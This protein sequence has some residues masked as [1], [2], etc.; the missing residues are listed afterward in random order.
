VLLVWFLCRRRRRRQ[1]GIMFIPGMGERVVASSMRSV[2]TS[3]SSIEGAPLHALRLA[4]AIKASKRVLGGRVHTRWPGP[5][6]DSKTLAAARRAV[7]DAAARHD[8]IHSRASGSTSS[9]DDVLSVVSSGAPVPGTPW[10]PQPPLSES[11]Q[12][13]E[14]DLLPVRGADQDP[15][16]Q[17]LRAERERVNAEVARMDAE[18]AHLRNEYAEGAPPTYISDNGSDGASAALT[19]GGVSVTPATHIRTSVSGNDKPS[20]L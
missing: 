6:L 3:S 17:A 20:D 19:A 1:N 16:F 14:A 11:E 5:V 7:L 2:D 8:H 12:H 13:V 10:T 15:Y 4:V 18:L 9:P